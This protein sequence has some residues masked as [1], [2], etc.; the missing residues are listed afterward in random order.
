[1]TRGE[2]NARVALAALITPIIRYA[3]PTFGVSIFGEPVG[4]LLAAVAALI[5]VFVGELIIDMFTGDA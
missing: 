1:M 3:A 2:F 4:W 5:V